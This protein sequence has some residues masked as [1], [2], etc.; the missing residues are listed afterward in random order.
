MVSEW[1]T[2]KTPACFSP[3]VYTLPCLSVPSIG[4][5]WSLVACHQAGGRRGLLRALGNF[6]KVRWQLY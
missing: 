4:L 1:L 2:S 3:Q 6:A 5:G